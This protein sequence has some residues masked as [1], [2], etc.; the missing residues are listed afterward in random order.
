[1][2]DGVSGFTSSRRSSPTP[3]SPRDLG[4]ISVYD[5]QGGKMDHGC[6][7]QLPPPLHPFVVRLNW[8]HYR[9]PIALH[10][11]ID[12]HCAS[13]HDADARMG[14]I[15]F[16]TSRRSFAS[17]ARKTPLLV[18]TPQNPC[19]GSRASSVRRNFID[20]RPPLRTLRN[21]F[22]F[23]W[24]APRVHPPFDFN[25]ELNPSISAA[26][27]FPLGRAAMSAKDWADPSK[28]EP[29]TQLNSCG[30]T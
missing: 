16:A 7:M 9:T 24:N 25:S 22:R 17:V 4:R 14:V 21:Q 27:I 8:P 13:V 10:I 11:L 19:E 1:M 6:P 2:R 15:E 28:S 26:A 5:L 20:Y 12:G 30:G 3:N 29:L 18:R 23:L